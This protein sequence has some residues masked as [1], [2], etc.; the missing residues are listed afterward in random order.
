MAQRTSVLRL[1]FGVVLLPIAHPVRVAER[2]A[3]LDIVSKGRVDFGTGRST[4]RTQ[5]DT[6][7]VDPAE[8]RDRWEE[9]VDLIPRLWLEDPITYHGRFYTLDGRSIVPKPVQKP[10]PPMF[11]ACGQAST[12]ELAG[13]KG[14]GAVGFTTGNFEE[15]Q[16][17][18]QLYREALRQ[19]KP[20]G[21]VVNDQL[22]A[23]TMAHCSERDRDARE[24]AGPE[25]LWY[26]GLVRR[27]LDSE[28]RNPEEVPESYRTYA[29]SAGGRSSLS[30]YQTP[31]AAIDRGLFIMGDPDACIRQI[32]RYEACGI[33]FLLCVM[34]IGR[35]PH[36]KIKR[37]IQLFGKH[38]IPHFK[39]KHRAAAP[40]SKS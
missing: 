22:G 6:F 9:S 16:R 36:E 29:T 21:G 24:L 35:V 25:G 14:I 15:I 11:V 4:T 20:P 39:A 13:R 3:M 37:S 32:E 1:G 8:T 2:V 27:Q 30:G 17:R 34:Q 19:A 28:W 26:F 40:S 18:T 10:H 12:Y 31:D 38:V 7:G 33:Q 5:L 23:W